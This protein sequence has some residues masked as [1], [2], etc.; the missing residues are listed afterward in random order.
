[1]GVFAG[2]DL[3]E[4]GLVLA[5]DAG[6]NKSHSTNRFVS[7]GTGD[8]TETVFP[9]VRGTSILT[10]V[11]TGTVVGGYTVKATDVVYSYA[12][13]TNSCHYQGHSAPIPAGVR[14][15]F[16]CDYL[17]SNATNYPVNSTLLVFENYGGGALGGSVSAPNSLQNVWQRVTFTS[18][19]TSSAGTQAMFLYPGGCG[20]RLAD[21]GTVYFR[22]PKVEWTNLDTGDGNFSSMPNLTTWY[23]LNNRTNNGTLTNTPYHFI[24]ADGTNGYMSFDGTNDMIIIPENSALNTQTPS[25]EV[26]VKTNATTQNGF[27]FEKGQVNTQ[28]SLFQEGGSIQ[29][30]QNFGGGHT[31]LSTTTANFMNTSNWYQV[32]GT[33]TSGTRRLYINGVLVNSD[34]QGGTIATNA[35][36]MSIGVYGGFNGDRGYY[37]NGNIASVKV[38][39]RALT[40]AEIQQNFNATKS[41]YGL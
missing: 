26:W 38:Y 20:T 3:S 9:P 37:Y 24:G 25:V 21:S 23:D 41:R 15:T 6:N 30:R 2:P 11:A 18:G 31:N 12:L 35:N 19:P 1:M 36:G 8:V 32:V 7:Y 4:S 40:A 17:V 29:W 34:T 13:G 27:W 5:L 39:N 33:F 28:Y 10:R 22:N 16:S 14:A